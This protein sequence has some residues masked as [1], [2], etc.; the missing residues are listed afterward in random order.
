LKPDPIGC[1]SL[2]CGSLQ[3]LPPL[4]APL[5]VELGERLAKAGRAAD[6][7]GAALVALV[8][9]PPGLAAPAEEALAAFLHAV[10]SST[11][12]WCLVG[13]GAGGRGG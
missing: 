5:Q 10:R 3:L 2:P 11:C 1:T 13:L 7:V 4:F 9:P 12:A 8:Q 6:G